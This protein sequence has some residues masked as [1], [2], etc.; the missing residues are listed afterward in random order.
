MAPAPSRSQSPSTTFLRITSRP[1]AAPA[2]LLLSACTLLL[3]SCGSFFSCEGKASCPCATGV[4]STTTNPCTG[5]G[6]GSTTVDYAYVTNSSSADTTIDGYNL[7]AGT[8]VAATS[9][10]FVLGYVPSSMVVT[11]GNTFLYAATDSVLDSGNGYVYGYSIGTGGALSIIS[12]G[13]SLVPGEDISSLAVSPD[14]Q[15]LFCLDT[16]GTLLEEY[17]INAST[18][19][20]TFLDSYPV[21]PVASGLNATPAQ[22]T[23]APSGDFVVV[24]L[25]QGGA[26]TFTLDETTGAATASKLLTPTSSA[27]GI[28]AAAVDVNN[29]IYLA[30]TNNLSVYSATTAGVPTFLNSYAT[31]TGT[32]HSVVVNTA[33]TYVYTGNESTS[34]I[35]GFSI[36]TNAALSA[37]SGSP[38]TGPTTVNALAFDSTM[39]YLIA[40]GYNASTG[41]QLFTVG[42]T[43]ALTAVTTSGTAGTG[44]TTAV[45]G[46][47]AATH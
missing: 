29:Y 42:S 19:A 17:S 46:A 1:S 35:Y 26:E 10:P 28:Y 39:A 21:G 22:V 45:P 6:T 11:P 47:I 12:S 33:G 44:T 25:G 40:S 41:I 4:T 24:A 23:V 7:G 9:A 31:G 32:D 3:S 30:G 27:T 14:G 2:L 43:G 36:G 20:L 37:V 34:T 16:I 13:D 18:G 8:L 15:Y 5:G 38:F